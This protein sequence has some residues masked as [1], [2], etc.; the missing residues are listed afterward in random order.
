M[1]QKILILDR[2]LIFLGSANMTS[3]SLRMHDNLVI[4]L[5]SPVVAKFLLEHPPYTSGSLRT[6]VGGQDLELHLLPDPQGHVISDL[7]RFIRTASRSIKIALFTFTHAGLCEEVIAAKRRGVE[8]KIVLDQHS[9]LG[10]SAKVVKQLA[11]AGIPL[12]LS[13]GVQL[14]HHKF[15]LIDDELLICGSANWTKAA[16]CKNSDCILVLHRLTQE[17]KQFMQSLWYRV[18]REG[19]LAG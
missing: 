10:A 2:D 14:L 5:R 15:L 6:M 8:V 13:R 19:V 11:E 9:S 17:Q 12:L 16:F 4:G 3:A 18:F 1:H 7:S